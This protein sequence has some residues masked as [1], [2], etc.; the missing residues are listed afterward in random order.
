MALVSS[1]EIIEIGM[2]FELEWGSERAKE[3]KPEP[4]LKFD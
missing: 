4:E 2:E 1:E 3:I